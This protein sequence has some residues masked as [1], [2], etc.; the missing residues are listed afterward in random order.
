MLGSFVVIRKLTSLPI[1]RIYW[2]QGVMG[3]L[4]VWRVMIGVGEG[5]RDAMGEEEGG[6]DGDG[7]GQG[8]SGMERV[9]GRVWRGCRSVREG[10]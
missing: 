1:F 7:E 8:D 5:E 3:T 2:H 4:H 9:G 6:E 10:V